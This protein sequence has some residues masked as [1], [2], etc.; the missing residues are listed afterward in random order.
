M[1]GL[2]VQSP[3]PFVNTSYPCFY[4]FIPN[5]TFLQPYSSFR[6]GFGRKPPVR[7]Q[8]AGNKGEGGDGFL[9]IEESCPSLRRA[10]GFWIVLIGHLRSHGIVSLAARRSK[11]VGLHAP[12]S[13][14][15]GSPVLLLH[16]LFIRV[17][18]GFYLV[19]VF[20]YQT[21]ILKITA[22][23]HPF[24]LLQLRLFCSA[25]TGLIV[26]GLLCL[27]FQREEL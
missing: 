24:S 9:G 5:H 26:T 20:C 1:S 27:T 23:F 18:L 14:S 6:A 16:F 11:Q 7:E 10:Q 13:T 3:D 15:G 4:L 25:Q 2:W 22:L 17:C 12:H 19:K 8:V 21:F